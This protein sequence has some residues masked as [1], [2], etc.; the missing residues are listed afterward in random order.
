MCRLEGELLRGGEAEEGVVYKCPLEEKVDEGIEEVPDE[1][2][3]G[4][5]AGGGRK[6]DEG[7]SVRCDEQDDCETEGE[8]GHRVSEK[9]TDG[10]GGRGGGGHCGGNCVAGCGLRCTECVRRESRLRERDSG[11]KG[12]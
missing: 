5:C 11:S 2:G 10:D 8:D 9:V 7:D 3:A 6:R 4:L 1:D 12:L